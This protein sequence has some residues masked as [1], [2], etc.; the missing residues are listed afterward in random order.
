MICFLVA[1]C[2][3][4]PI[5]SSDVISTNEVDSARSH[6]QKVTPSFGRNALFPPSSALWTAFLCHLH[7]I[8]P[9]LM[10]PAGWK[11]S[12]QSEIRSSDY[13]FMFCLFP[14]IVSNRN[15]DAIYLTVGILMNSLM[16]SSAFLLCGQLGADV[17]C[18]LIKSNGF[19]ICNGRFQECFAQPGQIL[20]L[21][22]S[23]I[24]DLEQYSSFESSPAD[25]PSGD[26]SQYEWYC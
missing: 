2:I 13:V 5:R 24:A 19:A 22:G 15:G 1:G 9:F 20:S 21:E 16:T 8:L 11:L 7:L 3:H 6:S 17:G 26:L 4:H 12:I 14:D 25:T 23:S 18:S 10:P